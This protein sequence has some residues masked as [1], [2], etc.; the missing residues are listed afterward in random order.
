[1]WLILDAHDVEFDEILTYCAHNAA[2][3]ALMA[4]YIVDMQS[5]PHLQDYLLCVL[6]AEDG[7]LEGL[8]WIG[9]NIVPSGIPQ[10]AVPALVR[11]IRRRSRWY[12]SIVGPQEQVRAL[13]AQAG[14][15]F[16]APREI[17]DVQPHL[18]MNTRPEVEPDPHVHATHLADVEVLIPAAVAMFTEEVGYSPLTA[19]S[20]YT[21]RVRS[22]VTE[23]RSLCRIEDRGDGREVVFKADLGTVGFGLTQI[24]GVWVNPKYRGQGLAAPA[25]A[26]VVNYAHQHVA[27]TV[28]LYVNDFNVAALATYARVGFVRTGTF[29]TILY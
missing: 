15:A 20:G 24:Q 13:Y 21:R 11:E 8:C 6:N 23:G 22:L 28:S 26:S 25:M 5:T 19:G 14:G 10:G 27:P 17:R 1:M 18:G 4:E 9:G 2:E 16:G 7:H 3:V 12:S 29:S